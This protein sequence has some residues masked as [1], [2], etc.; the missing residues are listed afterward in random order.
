MTSIKKHV[1][2]RVC[3]QDVD[4]TSDNQSEAA[5]WI[6]AH[7]H[8]CM[9]IFF[10]AARFDETESTYGDA[11]EEL[12]D[13]ASNYYMFDYELTLPY[14][15]WIFELFHYLK[16]RPDVLKE[17]ELMMKSGREKHKKEH[18]ESEQNDNS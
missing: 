14:F 13:E 6:E 8:P 9:G 7:Q 16:K 18:P 2:C 10:V 1:K 15:H 12:I 11:M 3:C 17:M 4:L 5:N